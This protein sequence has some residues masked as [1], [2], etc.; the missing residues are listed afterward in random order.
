MEGHSVWR[1]LLHPSASTVNSKLIE[2]WIDPNPAWH[3]MTHTI[4]LRNSGNFTKMPRFPEIPGFWISCLFP[5][6]SGNLPNKIEI[7]G[8]F[9]KVTGIFQPLSPKHPRPTSGCRGRVRRERPWAWCCLWWC[10]GWR[11]SWSGQRTH[12]EPRSSSPDARRMSCSYWWSW[13]RSGA[14]PSNSVS[15]TGSWWSPIG[16]EKGKVMHCP[17]PRVSGPIEWSKM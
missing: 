13:W 17:V 8:Y 1:L 12:L 6:H 11:I 16:T 7:Q 5:S 10:R 9:G 15:G 2:N 4:R 14:H 3:R